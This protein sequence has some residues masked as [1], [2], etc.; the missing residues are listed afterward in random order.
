MIVVDNERRLGWGQK[1]AKRAASKR[2]FK[3]SRLSVIY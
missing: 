3:G 2:D 1:H